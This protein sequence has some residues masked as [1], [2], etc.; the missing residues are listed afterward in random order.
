MY[1]LI[2]S[3]VKH[4]KFLL[5]DTPEDSGIDDITENIALFDMAL[6]LSENMQK[7]YQFILTT[8]LEKCPKEYAQHIRLEF[9]K[10]KD[11]FILNRKGHKCI[12]N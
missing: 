4:P 10:R 6:E 5:M 9:N 12:K 11:N 7:D 2:K 8:G 1:F 3:K